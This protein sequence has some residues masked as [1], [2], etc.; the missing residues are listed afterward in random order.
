MRKRAGERWLRSELRGWLALVLWSASAIPL[1]PAL[2]QSPTALRAV[3]IVR[4]GEKA[5]QPK[6]NPPL[7]AAGKARAQ[8][9][10]E[11]L[12]DA[13]LTTIITTDQER[14][15]ATASPLESAL[16][17]KGVI[18]PRTEVPR[19]DAAAIAAAV[20]QAGGTVLVVTHQ[21]TIPAIIAA[22]GGPAV[23]TMCDTEFSNL[24]VMIPG[25][26]NRLQL[27]R[28][29]YGSADPPHS[30]DCHITPVSPP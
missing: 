3:V 1:A 21:L 4:H 23:A 20:R 25:G 13:G 19:N 28:G 24:Y 17:L 22:L 27:I 18:V 10:L 26:S 12:R 15:R 30:A 6:D 8:S 7:S 9:L 29:H 16:H 14:T 2:A 11:T 5:E